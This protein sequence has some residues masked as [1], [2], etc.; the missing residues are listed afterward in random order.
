MPHAREHEARHRVLRRGKG[1]EGREMRT[2]YYRQGRSSDTHLIADHSDKLARFI[3]LWKNMGPHKCLTGLVVFLFARKEGGGK[4]KRL[5]GRRRGPYYLS[6]I[7]ESSSGRRVK[8][9]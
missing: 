3:H 8:K 4:K 9:K 6:P 7:L 5:E 1:Q 2:W